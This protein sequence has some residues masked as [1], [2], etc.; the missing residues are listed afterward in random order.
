MFNN[1]KIY[2][3]SGLMIFVFMICLAFVFRANIEDAY[4]IHMAKNDGQKLF[5]RAWALTKEEY[6]DKTLNHQEWS[7]W[8]KRY[9]PNIKTMDDSYIAIDSMLESLDDPYTRF[10]NP[11]DFEDQN[12]NID[13]KVYGIGINISDIGGRTVIV[14]VIEDT[15]AS[16]AKLEKGDII[17]KINDKDVKGFKLRDVAQL[18]R[19]PVGTKVKLELQRD[20]EKLTKTIVRNEI[21]IKTVSHDIIEKENIAHITITSFLSEELPEEFIQALYA[22]EDTKGLILD[23]RGNTGGLLPNAV[24]LANMFL[25]N[26]T[27]VSIV[28]RN[29]KKNDIKAV[30]NNFYISKPTVI[31]I[32]EGSASASEIFSGAMKDYHKAELIG[33]KTFGKGLV[34]KV[35]QLPYKAGMNITIA[36]YLTPSGADINKIGITPDFEVEYTKEDYI[37]NRDPQLDKAIAVINN[38]VRLA[39]IY[40][41]MFSEDM[42]PIH[43]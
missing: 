6:Y 19:G 25:D 4:Y 8:R 3:L 16:K 31:L 22:T 1:K 33:E 28:D 14:N 38:K 13:A 37:K 11:Y 32:N 40:K 43:P 9:V 12:I 35:E 42:E 39:T 20:E 2:L 26:G 7:Y 36:K 30:E 23:L 34:Q 41:K 21:K 27:I 29:G 24:V 17:L 18:V 5:L 10:M 15:P